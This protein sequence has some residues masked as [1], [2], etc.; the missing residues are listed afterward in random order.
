MKIA[1][2]IYSQNARHAVKGGRWK[3][4][5]WG[6]GHENGNRNELGPY[7]LLFHAISGQI[8]QDPPSY[9]SLFP[10]LPDSSHF[11]TQP[12]TSVCIASHFADILH[13]I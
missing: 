3:A 12:R 2:M 11:I 10:A 8:S 6:M 1:E 13:L 9:C 4:R 5:A 7:V